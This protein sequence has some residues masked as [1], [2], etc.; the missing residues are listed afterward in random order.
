[1]HA[2]RKQT[3]FATNSIHLSWSAT[4]CNDWIKIIP[5]VEIRMARLI[6][7]VPALSRAYFYIGVRDW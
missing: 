1:M 4:K 6:A 3:D 2:S 5:L 7:P